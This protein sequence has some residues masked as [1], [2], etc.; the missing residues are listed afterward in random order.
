MVEAFHRIAVVMGVVA[1]RKN[2]EVVSYHVD[3]SMVVVVVVCDVFRLDKVAFYSIQEVVSF[4]VDQNMVVV[5]VVEA[6]DVF[7]ND[8]VAFPKMV[9]VGVVAFCMGD[10]V[11]LVRRMEVVAFPKMEEE[12]VVVACPRMVV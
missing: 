5:V 1:F 2:Q 7:H 12:V 9:V 11:F 8:V 10:D 4:H 6:Y 3:Q